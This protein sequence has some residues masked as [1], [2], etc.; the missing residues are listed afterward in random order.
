M[1]T[2]KER[3]KAR[4]G[5]RKCWGMGVAISDQVAK[6]D[7]TEKVTFESTSVGSERVTNA[8]IWRKSI[9]GR[10]PFL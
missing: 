1:K 10:R 5:T 7:L 9:P 2:A 3:K 4:K 6:E 8:D